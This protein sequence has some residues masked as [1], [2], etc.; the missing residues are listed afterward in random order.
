MRHYIDDDILLSKHHRYDMHATALHRINRY[1]SDRE[2]FVSWNQTHS[3]SPNLNI[4]L[5]RIQFLGPF[6]FLS[7]LMLLSIPEIICNLYVFAV[8]TRAYIFNV[9]Q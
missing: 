2:H 4:L 5:P 9:I 7:T 3:P 1:L 6:C 8:D